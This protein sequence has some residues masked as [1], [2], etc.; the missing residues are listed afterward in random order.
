MPPRPSLAALTA[1]IATLSAAGP[2]VA[3][4]S[5]DAGVSPPAKSLAI[6]VGRELTDDGS[7]LLGGFGHEPSSH[8]YE[9]TPA[10]DFPAGTTI[11][12]GVTA[13]ASFP[14]RRL[15]IPQ[16]GTTL[17]YISTNYSEFA[18]FPPPLTNGGLNERHVAARDVWSPS[19]PELV[20]MTPN[21]QTGLS[22]S[23][24]SRIVMERAT[25]A[26]EAVAIL[27]ALIDEHGYATYG[28]NSHLF[29]DPEEGWV[30]ID[31]AGGQGLWAAERLRPDEVRV[32][33]PGYIRDFPVDFA[34]DP[35]FMGSANLVSFAV[36]RGWWDANGG[37]PFDLHEVYGRPFPSAP[38]QDDPHDL[39]R[40]PPLLE[41]QISALAPIGLEDMMAL[42]RDPRWSNDGAGY[43]QVAHL[44]SQVRPELGTLWMSITGAVASPFVPVPLGARD[45][46]PEYKQHRYMTKDSDTD[47]VDSQFAPLEGTVSAF[48]VHK[49]LLYHMC[50]DPDRFLEPVTASLE[51]FESQLVADQF[52]TEQR[53]RQLIDE[54]RAAMIPDILT[55]QA[56]QSLLDGLDLGERLATAVEVVAR[57]ER[58]IRMPDVPVPE[59]ATWRPESTPM[60]L[61]EGNTYHRCWTEGRAGYPRRHGT[62]ADLAEE[63]TDVDTSEL[64]RRGGEQT[65]NDLGP[66]FAGGIVGLLMG[67]AFGVFLARSASGQGGRDTDDPDPTG[68]HDAH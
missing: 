10:R 24:L 64:R 62:F 26:R 66:W 32:S 40:N 68:F 20:A 14:G 17:R 42:V 55:D 59:G 39:F 22:Y 44:R 52:E 12:V 50:E 53:V 37:Q 60:T 29:A 67:V 6:Y 7:V 4:S 8:W 49:R 38:G 43:G 41:E 27:G 15:R 11:E 54:G 33:Y 13:E 61:R 35:D 1:M 36:A 48:N 19:R 34:D 65:G 23:D 18:G 28:G 3:Q 51:A 57:R 9:V 63:L 5:S 47:F 45:V 25:S 16:V 31:Y 56:V 30:V 58:G 21:P 46:P 2:V